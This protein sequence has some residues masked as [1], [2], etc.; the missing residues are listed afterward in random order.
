MTKFIGGVLSILYMAINVCWD[1]A[2]PIMALD[3][4]QFAVWKMIDYKQG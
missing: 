1:E 4:Y 2:Q 3:H